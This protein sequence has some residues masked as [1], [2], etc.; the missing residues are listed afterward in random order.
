MTGTGGGMKLFCAGVGADHPD[1]T[2][3][4]RRIKKGEFESCQKN[5]VK[6]IV[7]IPVGYDGLTLA[8]SKQGPALNLTLAHV[9]LALAKQ[10]PGAD[11]KLVANPN[12]NWSDV[13]PS[14]PSKKIEVLGPPPTS[15][16]RDS[17]VELVME[18]GAEGIDAM[19]ALKKADAKA[20]EKAWKSLREDGAYVEA[21]ENDN[22]IVQKL[23][24]NPDALG[25][26]GYS[27]VEENL[28][29]IKAV[30]ID[31]VTPT[32]ETIASG[33]YK[34]A[35]PLFIYVKAQHVDVIPGLKEFIAEYVS[36]KALGE[37]GYL[38]VM[39]YLDRLEHGEV[40]QV[41]ESL[42]RRT[43]RP[44]TFGWGPRFLHSTGQFHKGG[45]K[46]GRFLQLID[47]PAGDLEVPGEPFTFGTLVRAQADGEVRGLGEKCAEARLLHN[48][49]DRLHIELGI[50]LMAC[51]AL[52][53][54]L[55][56]LGHLLRPHLVVHRDPC[57]VVGVL[58]PDD[59]A[60]GA[61]HG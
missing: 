48:H 34:V 17:F 41:R 44:V 3:A 24:A 55:D 27:F 11:G 21:G 56:A 5:G 58:D 52:A 54:G 40:E 37:D 13:D 49:I 33:A 57:L 16:T 47:E 43:G 12:K 23:G 32:Y 14:L 59:L 2:N 20:Y 36:D 46:V 30:P 38:A 60:P 35:R 28:N 18:K 51:R 8:Q 61:A 39:T 4:S 1:A 50:D 29:T 9:Y 19:Q 26:F 45:P 42:A 15:G 22:L 31:G 6:D 53:H 10:V 7:E 25:I